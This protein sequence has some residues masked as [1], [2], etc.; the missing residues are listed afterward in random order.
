VA[1]PPG[2]WISSRR[3]LRS[4]IRYPQSSP[5]RLSSPAADTTGAA[6][7]HTQH[8]LISRGGAGGR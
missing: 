4:S 2:K 8:S 5:S 1:R 3:Y 7:S 6:F